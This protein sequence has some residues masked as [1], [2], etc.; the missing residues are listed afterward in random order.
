MM[1]MMMSFPKFL[2]VNKINWH[3]ARTVSLLSHSVSHIF[4]LNIESAY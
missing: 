1:M 2:L 3:T 4:A